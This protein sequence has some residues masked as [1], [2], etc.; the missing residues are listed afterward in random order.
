MESLRL[1]GGL[2]PVVCRPDAPLRA[3]AESISSSDEAP[4]AL[5]SI[6]EILSPASRTDKAASPAMSVDTLLV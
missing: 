5:Q 4:N 1:S 6:V 2:E 3:G